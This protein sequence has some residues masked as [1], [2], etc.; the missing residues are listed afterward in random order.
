M[1]TEEK[2]PLC[3]RYLDLA[4]VLHQDLRSSPMF[5]RLSSF[6]SEVVYKKGEKVDELFNRS[7]LERASLNHSVMPYSLGE[8]QPLRQDLISNRRTD[9]LLA[10]NGRSIEQSMI[11]EQVE[12]ENIAD[13]P[14]NG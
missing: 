13:S 8:E 12:A 14:K 2:C 11:L 7:E 9:D 6:R 10:Q 1:E 3:K 5:K 4:A